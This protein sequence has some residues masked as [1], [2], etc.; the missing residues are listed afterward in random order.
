MSQQPIFE[1]FLSV[2]NIKPKLKCF[3]AEIQAD[4]FLLNCPP[5][6]LERV[7]ERFLE[8]GAVL[9]DIPVDDNDLQLRPLVLSLFA[10]KSIIYLEGIEWNEGIHSLWFIT[11]T[12]D[13]LQGDPAPC[14]K[15]PV[16]I[17][18]KVAV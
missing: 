1:L 15:P 17:D 2:G 7:A 8:K 9:N 12:F 6:L 4:I 13:G 18:V 10:K 11:A 5:G 16:Y 14:S 3:Q